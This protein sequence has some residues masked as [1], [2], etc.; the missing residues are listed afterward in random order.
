M[1]TLRIEGGA[2]KIL[3]IFKLLPPPP[4]TDNGGV[5]SPL[6]NLTLF[7]NKFILKLRVYIVYWVSI[8]FKFCS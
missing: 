1:A 7:Y 2:I 3:L 4:L 6:L 8:C 5:N